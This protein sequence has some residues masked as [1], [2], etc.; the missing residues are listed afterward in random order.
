[1]LLTRHCQVIN[2]KVESYEA[3]TPETKHN[4]ATLNPKK[5]TR[6]AVKEF[7]LPKGSSMKRP[8]TS[9]EQSPHHGSVAMLNHHAA[10]VLREDE[11]GRSDHVTLAQAS[12]TSPTQG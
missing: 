4:T 9:A 7:A 3:P 2:S 8:C 12:V 11:L 6:P 5:P 10:T 1:M